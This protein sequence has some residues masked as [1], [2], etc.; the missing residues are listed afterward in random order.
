MIKMSA[1]RL[2]KIGIW[3]ASLLLVGGITFYSVVLSGLFPQ[4]QELWVTT[5]MTTFSHKWLATAFIDDAVIQEIM[6]R[7]TVNDT[8]Y[9]TDVNL[10]NIKEKIELA[11]LDDK[12][13]EIDA[14]YQ[15]HIAGELAGSTMEYDTYIQ[16]GYERIEEGVYKKEVGGTG[17]KGYIA[18]VTDPS[19]VSLAQTRYQFER[20]DLVKT[21]V[22]TEEAVLG[23]NAG[24]FV[25]GPE[26]NS[27]GDM[28]AGLL[29]ANGEVINSWGNYEHSLIGFNEDNVLMLGK[30]TE[31]EAIDAKIRDCVD[32]KPFLIVNGETIIK[33]GNGG[34]GIA[35]R[36][37]I[38]QRQTG[39]VLF[40]CV[41]GRQAHSIGVDVRVLQDTLYEEGCVN[42]AMLDGGSSTVMYHHE[43]GYINKPSLGHERYI[44]NAWIVK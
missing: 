42:A 16:E 32:F 12:A 38:G 36:T 37:A 31:Q 23:V 21:M 15:A 1:R 3:G 14:L 19:R 40:L 43:L 18:L 9:K 35:P 8:G 22:E 10:V 20:G 5:A 24:G 6:K 34:W 41:D 17:W 27:N 25:D 30:M 2:K 39:E 26:Y 7:N 44:N 11:S 13:L 4:I 29:I 28:P 33:E